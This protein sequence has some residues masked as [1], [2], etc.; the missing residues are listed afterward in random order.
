MNN[1]HD[2]LKRKNKMNLQHI[3]Y[4]KLNAKQKENYNF[5]K[6]ASVLAD[7]GFT[8]MRL[9]DDWEGADFIALHLDGQTVLRVQLK[10]RLMF[11]KK[12]IGKG[13]HIAFRDKDQIYLCPHDEMLNIVLTEE[14]MGDTKSWEEG[15]YS[16]PN[17][18]KAML[19]R[20]APYALK[21]V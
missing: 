17:P 20:L 3:E 12:Y 21:G 11:D 16:Y 2:C 4:S 5:H 15:A 8:S 6:V 1:W 9:S 14:K 19:A 18:S 7:Y 10:G 13:L